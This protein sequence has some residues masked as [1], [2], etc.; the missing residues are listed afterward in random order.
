VL[1]AAAKARTSGLELK[2]DSHP[3]HQLQAILGTRQL[4]II[5]STLIDQSP[6]NS[7]VGRID[8]NGKFLKNALV[9]NTFYEL[10]SGLEQKRRFQYLR[11]NDGQGVYAWIDYNNDGI[12]DLNEFEI[13]Q[14]V[15]QAQY[16]RIFV[17]STDYATVYANEWNQSIL[18]R[19]E[20]IWRNRNG[21]LGV[22]SK[23][24]NQTKI[25][26]QRKLSEANIAQWVNPLA[27]QIADNSLLFANAQLSNS[28]YFNRS[29]QRFSAAYNWSNNQSKT[30][31]ANGQDARKSLLHQ[32]NLRLNIGEAFA[33]EGTLSKGQNAAFA[34]YTSGRNYELKIAEFKP[35]LIYQKESQLRL[36]LTGG[37]TQ[38][39]NNPIYGQEKSLAQ[40][41]DFSWKVN[42]SEQSSITGNIKYIHFNFIGN[43]Q[44]A[45][46]YEMLEG[47][48]AGANLTWGLNFQKTLGKNLQLSLHYSGRA[49]Q[50][51]RSIHTGGMELRAFF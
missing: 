25:R 15:D 42:K 50:G 17:P 51:Q 20:Q 34:D 12:K 6:E 21:V 11:V 10:G 44:S 29:G 22:L 39:Q 2:W 46:A 37:L 31:L 9:I 36:S 43:Q 5:D 8:Y 4:S 14:F 33:F 27:T 16:I 13:A 40:S 3:K 38:K 19:P 35:Q 26:V 49:A 1:S 18:W 48:R 7:A 47:L 45:V 28:I 23:F 24:S 30:L 41:A 32:L